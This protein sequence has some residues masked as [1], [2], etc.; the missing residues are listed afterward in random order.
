MKR[1]N[2]GSLWLRH[3]PVVVHAAGPHHIAQSLQQIEII[4][5]NFLAP[6]R[7]FLL[8]LQFQCYVLPRQRGS[9]VDSRRRRLHLDHLSPQILLYRGTHLS[10]VIVIAPLLPRPHQQILSSR[11]H[12]MQSCVHRRVLLVA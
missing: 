2:G 5:L 1:R 7:F 6:F 12:S 9:R 4:L 10:S 11:D 8:L 3:R